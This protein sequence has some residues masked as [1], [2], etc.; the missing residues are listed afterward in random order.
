MMDKS[1]RAKS[2][3]IMRAIMSCET[4]DELNTYLVSVKER[5]S[6]LSTHEAVAAIRC[7]SKFRD[8]SEEWQLLLEAIRKH[9]LTIRPPE[10]VKSLL[11]GLDTPYIKTIW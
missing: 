8:V 3:D 11:R 2:Q 7:S 9:L 5:V 4:L 10:D 1:D 6:E